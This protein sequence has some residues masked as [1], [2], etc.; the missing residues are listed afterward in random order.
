M[1]LIDESY[2]ALVAFIVG[3]DEGMER[4]LLAGFDEWVSVQL[5]GHESPVSWAFLIAGRHAPGILD[6]TRPCGAMS[7]AE[8]AG[9]SSELFDLLDEF[10]GAKQST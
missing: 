6:G 9:A 10:I 8:I 7:K 3:V 4:K 2:A 5:L 1:Y